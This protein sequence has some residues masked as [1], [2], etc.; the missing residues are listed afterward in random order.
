MLAG[1]TGISLRFRE[2]RLKSD[3]PLQGIGD[4]ARD[5]WFFSAKSS[6]R[7]SEL[8]KAY[9]EYVSLSLFRI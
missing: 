8:N 6:P 9:P 2:L 1:A 4:L 5:S 3:P 7:F